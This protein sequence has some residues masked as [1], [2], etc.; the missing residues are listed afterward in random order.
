M[1]LMIEYYLRGIGMSK[2]IYYVYRLIA[3]VF[4]NKWISKYYIKAGMKIGND[5][6]IFSKIICGEPYLVDIGSHCT[7]A[8]DVAL[9]THDA[10]IGAIGDRH[11]ASDLLGAI[12]IGNNCFIGHGV[13]VLY[14]VSI[15]DSVIVAA[16]SVVTKSITTSNV[17]IGGN[18]AKV[19]C[20]VD[21]FKA[22]H[23]G[24][25]FSLHGLKAKECEKIIKEN[26]HKLVK[27]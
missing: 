12:K 14:G 26:S 9:L 3:Y 1:F 11:R 4:G 2:L 22:K 6:R 27:R 17:V 13:I 8:T 16:G 15:A 24:H 25:F 18:P 7:I 20:S 5:T 21:D 19:I 23:R 10:S